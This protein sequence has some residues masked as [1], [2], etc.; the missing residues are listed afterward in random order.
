[1]WTTVLRLG[2]WILIAVLGL[3]VFRENSEDHIAELIT[4]EMLQQAL[5]LALALIA[6]SG[7]LRIF[8]KTT[9]VVAK[10]NRCQTCRTPIPPGA[11]FCR[12]HLRRV[13]EEENERTHLTKVRR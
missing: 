9:A 4:G 12:T 7:V 8:G 3:Y 6:L 1:M 2:L 11:L 5:T 10:K 13:L